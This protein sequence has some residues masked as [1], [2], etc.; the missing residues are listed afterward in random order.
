MEYVA[1][2]RSV[3]A[4]MCRRFVWI[5]RVERTAVGAR[6]VLALP[7]SAPVRLVRCCYRPSVRTEGGRLVCMDG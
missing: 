5:G 6:L 4:K 3:D 2:V 1:V 7:L